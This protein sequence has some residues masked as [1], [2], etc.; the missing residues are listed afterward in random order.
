MANITGHY[1]LPLN[2][3]CCCRSFADS[4]AIAAQALCGYR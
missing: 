1:R 4:P 2:G 3:V